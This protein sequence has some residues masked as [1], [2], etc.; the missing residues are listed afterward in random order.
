MTREAARGAMES[1]RRRAVL[2]VSCR[3]GNVCG[4]PLVFWA[5]LG[6]ARARAG[7]PEFLGTVR[8]VYTRK[9]NDWLG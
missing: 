1:A 2:I 3:R 9:N 8:D 6:G 4:P 7:F 5:S